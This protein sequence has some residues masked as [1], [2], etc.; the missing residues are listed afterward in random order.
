MSIV[1][2]RTTTEK[3]EKV[4]NLLLIHEDE[5]SHYVLVRDMSRLCS[6]QTTKRKKYICELCLSA[7]Y[8]KEENLAKHKLI[9]STNESCLCELPQEGNNIMRFKNYCNEFMHPFHIVADFESTLQTVNNIKGNTQQ[10]QKHVQNSFGLKYNC[11]Q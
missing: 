9:C 7:S 3:K 10:Y 4:V 1:P 2:L 5:K 11:I 8:E 6:S